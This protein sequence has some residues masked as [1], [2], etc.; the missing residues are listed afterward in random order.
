ML[1]ILKLSNTIQ[2]RDWSFYSLLPVWML[3]DKDDLV[4]DRK[5]NRNASYANLL[6]FANGQFHVCL[7][8]QLT[9]S[10]CLFQLDCFNV[11]SL[12]PVVTL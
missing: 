3:G 12:S 8:K 6:R 5:A 2:R 7:N 4:K 1:F 11:C 10:W 9:L